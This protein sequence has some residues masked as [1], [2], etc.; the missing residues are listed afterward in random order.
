[1][2]KRAFILPIFAV[3]MLGFIAYRQFIVPATLDTALGPY[4]KGEMAKLSLPKQEQKL[5]DHI[6]IREDGSSIAL[7]ELRGKAMLINLWA[8]W[9]APCRAEMPE[10]ANLQKLLGDDDFEVVAINVNR[11][12]IGEARATLKE[13]DIEGLGLYADPTMKIAIDL[14]NGALPTSLIVGKDG[15][16]KAMYLGPLKWDGP[17]A[18]GLFV[19]LKNGEI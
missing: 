13:W 17:E 1:M 12:G 15:L 7:S 9:C 2:P 5:S 14:A 3:L 18:I 16:V 4:L 10:L 11:G 6:I 19:A 8:P